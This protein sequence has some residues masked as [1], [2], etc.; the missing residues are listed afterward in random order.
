MQFKSGGGRHAHW[1]ALR[2]FFGWR[3]DSFDLPDPMTKMKP[4][5]VARLILPTL[6]L[7]EIKVL[8]DKAET[9]RDKAII[10]LLTE[11]GMR[12]SEIVQVGLTDIDWHERNIQ[13]MGKGRKQRNV[14]FGTLSETYLKQ[15]LREKPL[16]ANS[17]NV[18]GLSEWGIVSML[19]R[20]EKQSGIPC[21]PH[22]FGRS[23]TTIQKILG[24]DISIIKE[25]GG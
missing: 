18:W 7:P 16:E 20:L 4:P 24:T 15:W 11:S 9:I 3:E 2:A 22:V 1:R 14:P 5:K 10:A 19:R 21:N 13:V 25:L 17:V 23:F 8:F 6:R 12:L